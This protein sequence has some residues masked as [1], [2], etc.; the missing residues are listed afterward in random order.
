VE[1]EKQDVLKR[2]GKSKRDAKEKN[3]EKRTINLTIVD[4]FFNLYFF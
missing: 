3:S 1:D 4:R 2:N